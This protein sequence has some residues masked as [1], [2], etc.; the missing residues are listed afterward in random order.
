[1]ERHFA[2][3]TFS[4]FHEVLVENPWDK[5]LI[6]QFLSELPKPLHTYANYFEWKSAIPPVR[7]KADLPLGKSHLKHFTC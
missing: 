1:M 6:C 2:Y 3:S 5:E 4:S 7:L